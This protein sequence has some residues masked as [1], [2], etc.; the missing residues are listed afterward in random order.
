MTEW[1]FKEI[2]G[3][4]A[5]DQNADGFED[6]LSGYHDRCRSTLTLLRQYLPRAPV[7]GIAD[8]GCGMGGIGLF[9]AAHYLEAGC[10]S[11]E[12]TLIDGDAS[13]RGIGGHRPAGYVSF[14]ADNTPWNDATATAD[15]FCQFGFNARAMTPAA[16]HW[17]GCDMIVSTRSW[18]F[19]YPVDA[20]LPQALACL[21]PDGV[22]ALEIRHGTSGVEKMEEYFRLVGEEPA[23][24]S[25][26]CGMYVFRRKTA[27]R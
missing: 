21:Q 14:S 12:V 9:L 4:L 1:E 22:I 7:G 11:F 8:V 20:Y 15:R 3:P 10:T 25:T 23:V 19:H 6:R 2:I 26:K 5:G 27:G 16:Y 13:V 24:G 18:G 17:G